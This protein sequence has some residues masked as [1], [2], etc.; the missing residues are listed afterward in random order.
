LVNYTAFGG[1]TLARNDGFSVDG[2]QVRLSAVPVP[3]AGL[4][5]IAGLGALA[6]VRA[7]RRA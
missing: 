3:A 7:R 1:G 5:M 4:L 2:A 6:A